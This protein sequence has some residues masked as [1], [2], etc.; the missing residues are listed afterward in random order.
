MQKQIKYKYRESIIR[1]KKIV[2]DYLPD[3]IFYSLN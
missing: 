1:G 2:I 3:D